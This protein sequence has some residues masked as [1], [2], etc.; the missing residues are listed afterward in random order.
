M[1]SRYWLRL[2]AVALLAP[3]PADGI[4]AMRVSAI[5]N[6]ATNEDLS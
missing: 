6:A 5:V 3:Y 2:A 4:M 1:I